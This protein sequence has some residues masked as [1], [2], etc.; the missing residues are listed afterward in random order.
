MGRLPSI[1][2]ATVIACWPAARGVAADNVDPR[3]T[4]SM[5]ETD[6]LQ[7]QGKIREALASARAALDVRQKTSKDDLETA[8]IMSRVAQLERLTQNFAVARQLAERSLEIRSDMSGSES[9]D[10]ATS[11]FELAEIASETRSSQNALSYAQRALAIRE[12]GLP[13]DARHVLDSTLQMFV[14]LLESGDPAAARPYVERVVA[15][16]AGKPDDDYTA[17]AQAMLSVLANMS[18]D[19]EGALAH[20]LTALDIQQRIRP[21]GHPSLGGAHLNL[22]SANSALGRFVEAQQHCLESLAIYEKALGSTH[23]NVSRALNNLGANYILLGDFPSAL[24]HLQRSLDIRIAAFGERNATTI[25]AYAML[26][27]PQRGVGDLAAAR[28]T[29]DKALA[30]ANET[31]GPT[32]P[33]VA[34]VRHALGEQLQAQ[35]DP[36]GA[37]PHLEQALQIREQI[38]GPD[39]PD[40]IETR[41]ALVR[42]LLE[43]D[44]R[45]EAASLVLASMSSVATIS[46]PIMRSAVLESYRRLLASQDR[47]AEAVFYGKQAINLLQ[48]VRLQL[49]GLDSELQ[50]SFVQSRQ[51]VYRGLADLLIDQGRLTEAQEVLA[52]LKEQEFF[53]FIRRDATKDPRNG[54]AGFT[55]SEQ[56]WARRYD[57]I[58]AQLAGLSVEFDALSRKQEWALTTDERTRL[59]SLR[60]DL[61]VGRQAFSSFLGDASREFAQAGRFRATEFAAKELPGLGKVQEKLA[62]LGAGTVLIHYLVTD[63]RL[64]ILMTTPRVQLHRDS[65]IGAKEL[66]QLIFASREALQSPSADPETANAKLY[67][68]LM[69]PIAD[70]LRQARARTLMISPDDTLR[71]VSF[72]ALHDGKRYLIE[73]FGLAM[74]TPASKA[75]LAQQPPDKW[76]ISGFGVTR[77]IGEFRALPSVARE[78]DVVVREQA[79]T[80]RLGVIEGDTYIDDG[81]TAKSLDAALKRKYP[82]VHIASHFQ[83]T[84][85]DDEHSYLLLGDGTRLSAR[86]LREG[87]YDLSATDLLTLSACDTALT[88]RDADGREIEGLAGIAQAQGAK[89]VVATLW[90]VADSSTAV[91]MQRFYELLSE[92]GYDKARALRE[93][94]LSML[95]KGQGKTASARRHP[96]YW[97]PFILLGNWL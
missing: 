53:D 4:A 96:Y 64:R 91:F 3:V 29:L 87:Q 36:A 93:A 45:D 28:A 72:A 24:R 41:L 25:S 48:T 40:A 47:G 16:K 85:G 10:A 42:V 59:A 65:P 79:D 68:V 70:D 56:P 94:Q 76:R 97:G 51:D 12:K 5:A 39:S 38:A 69:R 34:V 13:P 9:L 27:Q 77:G 80:D 23:V 54:R 6:R 89:A 35:G 21:A 66:N 95:S 60:S 67:D 22:C 8:R 49:T 55:T 84:A 11:L 52:M 14:I 83:F 50:R 46:S 57:E 18:G 1:V 15:V 81:F 7:A 26:S 71:Y 88:S 43:L 92:R 19:L 61:A 86:A 62:G 73:R 74:Y 17:R 31:L 20:S 90:A 63:K 44:R 2:I 33:L 32:H 58:S 75:M 37:R 82:L 78:L 30:L